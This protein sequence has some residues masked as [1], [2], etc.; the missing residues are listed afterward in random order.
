MEQT[1]AK[2]TPA[3]NV[4]FQPVISLLRNQVKKMAKLRDIYRVAVESRTRLQAPGK[5]GKFVQPW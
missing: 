1:R 3:F 4:N 2:V 5:L